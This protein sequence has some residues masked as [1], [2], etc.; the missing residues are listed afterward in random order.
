MS[1]PASQTDPRNCNTDPLTLTLL[2]Q[3]DT[4][5]DSRRYP[6]REATSSGGTNYRVTDRSFLDRGLADCTTV[7]M[8][9][10]ALPAPTATSAC[11]VPAVTANP[12]RITKNLYD[13]A[14]QLTK[15]QKAFAITT[16]NGFPATLQQDYVTYTYTNNGKQQFVTDANVNKAQYTW[17]GFDRLSKWNF[18]DKVTHGVVSTTDFEQYTYDAAGNRLSLKRRDG[19]TLTFTYDNLNRMLSKLI[20]DGCPP[21]QPPG[22]GCPGT[23]ATRDV[24]YGYDILGRQLTAKFDSTGGADGITNAY[25]GFGNLASSA[26]AMSGF[27]KAVS[28]LYDLDN[29]RTRVT[30]PDTQA[31]T[32][33]YDARDRLT[34]IAE[35][36]QSNMISFGYDNAGRPSLLNRTNTRQ[37]QLQYDPI[38]RP[39]QLI[40]T[41]PGS[42]A[43]VQFDY[44]YNPA[45]QI[46]TQARSN[47]TYAFTAITTANNN[48][49][50]NGLN[51]YT[52]VTGSSLTYDASGNLTGDGTNSYIYDGENR[53]VSATAAGVTTTL[54]YDPLGRLWRVQK[55]AADT[56]LLYDGD[57]L[58]GE[59]DSSGALTKRY[60][61]GSNA[62]VDDPLVDYAGATLSGRRFLETDHQGS[63]ILIA[64][65]A[66]ATVS[67]NRYDEY[68]VPQSG[69]SGRFQYTGQAWLSEAGLYYYKARLYSPYLGR[70]LQTDPVGY[71]GG[72]NL[73][74]Y[75]LD[76]PINSTDPTGNGDFEANTCS[77]LGG[78]GCS[79]DYAGSMGTSE[80][81]L[82]IMAA[83]IGEPLKPAANEKEMAQ[84]LVSAVHAALEKACQCKVDPNLLKPL[85]ANKVQIVDPSKIRS[86]F[87]KGT[88]SLSLESKDAK[89]VNIGYGYVLKYYPKDS[90]YRGLNTLTITTPLSNPYHYINIPFYE[91][92]D[93][94]N[95]YNARQWCFDS[96]AC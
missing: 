73:Y 93:P 32:Y 47:D 14:G 56:R 44:T 67:T 20:P 59:Y 6:I 54:T 19:R 69:N 17:D 46:V 31:F 96:N 51:Q 84:N 95:S 10:A 30:H 49:S 92:G 29:N 8:N 82:F 34:G 7:R 87:S 36:G 55:A 62:A 48:Y 65:N 57:A 24:F 76:D 52:A 91:M 83:A 90:D 5:Y 12:D 71:E 11:A 94:V 78:G 15:I 3:T 63:V 81:S 35:F 21:I 70:F 64:D 41:S 50:I 43:N 88:G 37:S 4:T 16:A 9:M 2:E 39:N 18:P 33:A 89:S 40:N 74:A 79:G 45:S 85:D 53:L 42:P 75:A 77:R 28:S 23:P 68:G 22:T 58:V 60:V 1:Q 25:D 13:N 38:S 72:I 80:F 27:S 61:H 26:I 66:G 86:I